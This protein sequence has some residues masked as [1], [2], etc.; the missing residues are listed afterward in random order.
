MNR[1]DF[2]NRIRTMLSQLKPERKKIIVHN[3][4]QAF[5]EALGDVGVRIKVEHIENE[6]F[7]KH[8]EDFIDML[9]RGGL[10]GVDGMGVIRISKGEA[11]EIMK[12]K[13]TLKDETEKELGDSVTIVDEESMEYMHDFDTKKK[14]SLKGDLFGENAIVIDID[15]RFT[16]KCD[17]CPDEHKSDLILFYPKT[18]KK[19][20]AYSKYVKPI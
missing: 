17:H 12:P 6:E 1:E 4:I 3:L 18:G 16:F 9:K 7:P 10:T 19:Y 8:M 20:H 14:V 13:S 5:I 2:K 11:E 15:N